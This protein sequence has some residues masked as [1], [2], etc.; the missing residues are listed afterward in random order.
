MGEVEALR[1]TGCCPAPPWHEGGA[2]GG[3]RATGLV[4]ASGRFSSGQQRRASH[5]LTARDAGEEIWGSSASR[6]LVRAMKP[7]ASPAKRNSTSQ[8][9]LRSRSSWPARLTAAVIWACPGRAGAPTS[10]PRH[11]LQMPSS[12]LN[13]A[14]AREPPSIH[15]PPEAIHRHLSRCM[16]WEAA[17]GA[18]RHVIASD[19]RRWRARGLVV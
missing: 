9:P 11:R 10:S 12:H 5:P 13:P 8:S 15:C 4:R 17:H 7:L 19:W 3:W 6:C 18:A 16:P 14:T 2:S 1:A